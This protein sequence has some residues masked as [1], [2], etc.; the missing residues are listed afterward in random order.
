[1]RSLLITL[2][3]VASSLPALAQTAAPELAA[4][5]PEAAPAPT[6]DRSSRLRASHRVDV[7]APG[8]R[9]ESVIDRMRATRPAPAQV[10]PQSGQRPPVRGPDKRGDRGDGPPDGPRGP[11][12][13]KGPPGGGAPPDRP[14]R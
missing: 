7:I 3:L 4:P 6:A 14:H 5:T 13:G 2:A 10:A 12:G 11:P 8:E 9:V 1:M